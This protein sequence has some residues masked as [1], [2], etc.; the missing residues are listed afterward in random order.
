MTRNPR[1]L[2]R[3]VVAAGPGGAKALRAEIRRRYAV[4]GAKTPCAVCLTPLRPSLLEIDHIKAFV[5]GGDDSPE[6]VRALCVPCHKVKSHAD[7]GYST[8]PF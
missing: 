6:N 2:R 5:N 3:T 1:S 8:T 4:D 7:C